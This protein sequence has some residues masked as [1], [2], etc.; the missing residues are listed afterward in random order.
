MEQIGL[1]WRVQKGRA[2]DYDARHKRAWPE[3][4]ELLRRLGVRAFDIYRQG[5]TVFGHLEVE[6]YG[7]LTRD[8]GNDPIA[9]RW[10]AEFRDI[11]EYPNTDPTNGW[12]EQ[13]RHVWSLSET[14]TPTS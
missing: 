6:D 13:L 9:I 11:L 10:E 8:F 3:L 2:Y 12:P 1:I 5:D 4:E 14:E 7:R